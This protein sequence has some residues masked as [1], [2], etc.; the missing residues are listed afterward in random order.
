M[1]RL[2]VSYAVRHIYIYIYVFRRQRVKKADNRFGTAVTGP[3]Y[4]TS[5]YYLQNHRSMKEL[6]EVSLPDE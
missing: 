2:E 1:Q 4:E 6:E 3:L 5:A